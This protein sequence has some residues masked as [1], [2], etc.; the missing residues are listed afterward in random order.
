MSRSRKKNPVISNAPMNHSSAKSDKRRAN[1]SLRKTMKGILKSI[2][3]GNMD[4]DD[5][6]DVEIQEVSDKWTFHGDGKQW[7]AADEEAYERA[8]RK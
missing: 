4:D 2:Q 7:I 1:K 8:F 3:T 5:F 6:V